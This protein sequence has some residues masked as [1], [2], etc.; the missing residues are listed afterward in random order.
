MTRRAVN[1]GYDENKRFS[2]RSGNY[3][4]SELAAAGIHQWWDYFNIDELMEIYLDNYYTAKY[5]LTTDSDGQSF[6]NHSDDEFLPFCLPWIHENPIKVED[7]FYKHVE[8][9]KYYKPLRSD[10]TINS[11]LIYE[12]IMCYPIHGGVSD[13]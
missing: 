6:P 9:K 8:C 5:K 4:M 12:R 7:A 1:F 2:E 10:A 3:K 11:H 13:L